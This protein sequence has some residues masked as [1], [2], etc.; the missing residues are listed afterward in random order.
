MK[1]LVMTALGLAA[2]AHLAANADQPKGGTDETGPYEVVRDWPKPLHKDFTSGTTNAVW[3]QSANKVYVAQTAELPVLAK[4]I[5]DGG[6]PVRYATGASSGPGARFEHLLAVFD[7][8]GNLLDSWEQHNALF[9]KAHRIAVSPYDPEQHLWV[10]DNSQTQIFKFSNDGKKL[11][12]TVGTA[13]APGAERGKPGPGALQSPTDIAFLKNGDLMIAE[14]G[15][16]RVSRYTKD[17]KFVS[18][19]GTPGTGPGQ[20][21]G[22]MHGLA[23]D[24]KQ[25]L[26]VADR[27]NSRIQVFDEN[28]R[29]LDA[30]PDIKMPC[31]VG[32]SQD[33]FVWVAD[34]MRNRILKYNTSGRLLYSWGS[35]GGE[36]GELW[37][38][39]HLATD[40]EGNL[41]VAEVWNGRVQKFRPRKGADKNHLVGRL[42]WK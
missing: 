38:P 21:G 31:F 6:A 4:P 23:F 24:A 3:A 1:R 11:V 30:W 17:G 34:C 20:F 35:F 27:G 36:P 7:R 40:E 28:G 14:S 12:M 8:N 41:Y 25:R 13:P 10:L 37:G 15:A 9:K 29:F 39:H 19:F 32:V 2:V 16:P 5:G 33:Q 26:Y 42:F 18:T 22:Q